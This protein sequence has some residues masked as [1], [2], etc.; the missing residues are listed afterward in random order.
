MNKN[1]DYYLY[2]LEDKMYTVENE[3]EDLSDI[4]IKNFITPEINTLSHIFSNLQF[5]H[6]ENRNPDKSPFMLFNIFKEEPRHIKGAIIDIMPF[7]PFL[8]YNIN[9]SKILNN[10]SI[11]LN[12]DVKFHEKGEYK[13]KDDNDIYVL[14]NGI[15][16]SLELSIS[17]LGTELDKKLF[18]ESCGNVFEFKGENNTL[19]FKINKFIP[20][21][22]PIQLYNALK[23]NNLGHHRMYKF[24]LNIN[25]EILTLLNKI[26][27]HLNIN[28]YLNER[29]FL[30]FSKDDL[31]I[32]E[33]DIKDKYVELFSYIDETDTFEKINDEKIIAK[34]KVRDN[35]K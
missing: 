27:N 24:L 6:K 5:S 33:E 15:D 35:F 9:D 13:D 22:D 16:L 7:L 20:E 26:T 3:I 8:A 10:F 31:K 4:G 12:S 19:V 34:Y 1:K 2:K 28:F 11:N 21:E 18:N 32:K 23:K 29:Y 30:E 25:N 14:K 17:N